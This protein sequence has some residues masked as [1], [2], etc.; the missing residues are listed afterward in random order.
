MN[1]SNYLA[2]IWGIS[3]VVIPLAFLIKEKYLKRLF[4]EVENE[5]FMLLLGMASFILGLAMVLSHN[6]WAKNWTVIITIIGWLTLVKSLALLFFP[7][8]MK[9]WVKKVENK[10]WL[11]I[12]LV[13]LIFI[14]LVI[15]YFGFTAQ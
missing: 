13:V 8:Y 9:K 7:E 15:T 10:D 11:P 6:I 14:G 12:V 3:L 1:L 4:V 5:A 2:D